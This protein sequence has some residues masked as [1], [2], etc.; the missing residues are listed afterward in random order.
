[1]FCNGTLCFPLYLLEN[2]GHGSRHYLIQQVLFYGNVDKEQVSKCNR[3]GPRIP[4][5]RIPNKLSPGTTLFVSQN[6]DWQTRVIP[7]FFSL[8]DIVPSVNMYILL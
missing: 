1:M 4:A 2:S 7:M 3:L 6:L 5:H 8:L